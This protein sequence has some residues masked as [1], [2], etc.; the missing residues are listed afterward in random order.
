MGGL[1]V[2]ELSIAKKPSTGRVAG[3]QWRGSERRGAN[4]LISILGRQPI[5]PTRCGPYARLTTP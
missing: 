1:C 4:G 5:S 2:G 3:E